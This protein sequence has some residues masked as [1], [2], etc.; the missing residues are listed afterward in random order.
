MYD[1][2]HPL[3][4]A[5]RANPKDF[6]PRLAYADVLDDLGHTA[7]ATF[8]RA[9]CAVY[10][11]PVWHQDR[12]ADTVRAPLEAAMA[13]GEVFPGGKV[14][15]DPSTLDLKTGAPC[16]LRIADL[17]DIPADHFVAAVFSQAESC[18]VA[19]RGPDSY[20]FSQVVAEIV[21]TRFDGMRIPGVRGESD[22]HYSNVVV[23]SPHPAWPT[24]LVPGSDP[25][26]LDLSGPVRPVQ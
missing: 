23:F 15:I 22:F 5:M 24:W 13:A 9:H 16:V 10:Q 12:R 6:A 25:Y 18:K 20:L 26:R 3:L 7:A 21:S 17:T 4:R 2:I 14:Y 8:L 1:A 11:L 19:G